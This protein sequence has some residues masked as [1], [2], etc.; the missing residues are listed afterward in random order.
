MDDRLKKIE[1][2][3][4]FISN[5]KK[6]K[7]FTIISISVL[8][9]LGILVFFFAYKLNEINIKHN[10]E[11]KSKNDSLNVANATLDSLRNSLSQVNLS[12]ERNSNNYDSLKN[13]FDTLAFLFNNS[14]SNI[15]SNNL[16]QKSL[17]LDEL[18]KITFN[19][20]NIILSDTLKK[21]ILKTHDPEMKVNIAY[22]IYV[23]CM[24]EY[25]GVTSGVAKMLKEKKYTVP[26]IETI[27]NIT[28]NSV[29]KYFHD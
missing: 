21:S 4:Q 6:S 15:N 12:L 27:D 3:D 29:V 28:F 13:A 22:K 18:S 17:K 11:L 14:N 19:N 2:L 25:I 23:Q 1:M 10:R 24:P 8:C 20:Q 26:G 7:R 5:E 9:L 16:S